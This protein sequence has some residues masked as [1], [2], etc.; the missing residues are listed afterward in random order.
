LLEA[1]D[2]NLFGAITDDG[3]G[4]LS[5]SVGEMAQATNGFEMQLD[6]VPLKY[7]G[8]DPWQILVSESQERMT[9]AV[10]PKNW[11]EFSRLAKKHDVEVTAIGNFNDSGKFHTTYAGKAVTYIDMEFAHAGAPRM[12]LKAEWRTPEGRGLRE[13]QL[14]ESADRGADLKKILGR[15]NIAGKEYIQRQYDHEVLGSS[16]VKPL[17]GEGSEVFSDATVVRPVYDTDEGIAVAAGINPKYGIIDT[18]W[19]AALGIDEAVRRII[20]VGGSLKQIAL[21][22][23]FCWP[24]PLPAAENPDAAYKMAQLVRANQALYDFTMAYKTPCISGKD[25]MSMDGTLKKFDGTS[26]RLSALPTILFSAAGKIDDVKKCVTMDA[27]DSGDRVYVLGKTFDEL[28]GSEFYEMRGHVGLNVPKVDAS[29]SIELYAALSRAIAAG[30]V[31]SAHG[32]Y[33]GGLAVGLAQIAFGGGRGLEIDIDKVAASEIESADK[34]LYSESASRFVV[35]VSSGNAEAFESMLA[36]NDIAFVGMV[37]DSGELKIRRKG[38]VVI[39]EKISDLKAAWQ[40]T[41]A[42]F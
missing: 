27:K 22:D 18:Y 9:L 5:S 33:K 26:T 39:R 11:E 29:R 12:E 40:S 14:L 41:F 32:I 10:D 42:N 20:A 30:A 19:M 37:N 13:P 7:A 15:I 3:A 34:I 4:G 28:G 1:R 23:N 2:K 35:T 31:K 25:S 6:K 16:I 8:L 38:E 21:N 24:S 36:D 17:V